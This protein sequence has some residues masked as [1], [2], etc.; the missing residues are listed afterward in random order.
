MGGGP[1]GGFDFRR[2]SNEEL[3]QMRD[4]FMNMSPEER[5]AAFEEFRRNRTLPMQ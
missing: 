5:R 2:M 4:R 3:G 1:G